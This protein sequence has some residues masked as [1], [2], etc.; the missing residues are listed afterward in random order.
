MPPL[1]GGRIHLDRPRID[2]LLDEALQS[3]LVTVVAGAG[4]GKS[5]AVYSWL[6]DKDVDAA[7]LQFSTRDNI[8]D[9]FWEHFARSVSAF[10]PQ[11]AERLLQQGFPGTERQFERYLSIPV[12]GNDPRRRYVFVYD[13]IHLIQNESVLWFLNRSLSIPFPNITSILI[14]RKE[15]PLNLMR[16]LSKGTLAQI[17]GDQLRFSFEEMEALFEI[18]GIHASSETLDAVY[19]DTEGWAFALHLAG[20]YL[21]KVPQREG[22]VIPAI[23][24]NIFKLIESEV[25]AESGMELRKFLIKASLLHM[26][27]KE[28]LAGLDQ[29]GG[30]LLRQLDEI[31]TFIQLDT[32]SN[33]YYIHHLF[34]DYLVT[35]QQ[36]LTPEE[37]KDVW[38]QAARWSLA[39]GQKNDA[40][41]YYDK[42]GDYAAVMKLCSSFPMSMPNQTAKFLYEAM[43]RMP[44]EVYATH[45]NAYVIL[46]RLMVMLG[47]VGEAETLLTDIIRKYEAAPEDEFRNYVLW[48]AY[49]TIGF[50]RKLLCLFNG[51]YDFAEY[52]IKGRHYSDL[53]GRVLEGA[54]RNAS[55][56]AYA[57][58]V[59]TPAP[60][61]LERFI[62]EETAMLP[63]VA[64]AMAGCMMGQDWVSRG[65]TAFFRLD[66]DEAERCLLQAVPQA[67][68]NNQYDVESQALFYRL[69]VAI[70][71][72]RTDALEGVVARY[73]ELLGVEEHQNRF[74]YN[75]IFLGWFHAH[76][77]AVEKV[78]FWLRS[79]AGN[80]GI[81]SHLVGL[82]ELVRAKALLRER[83]FAASLASLGNARQSAGAFIFGKVEIAVLEALC[84]YQS[85]ERAKAYAKLRQAWEFAAPG[86]L[87]L[88]FAEQ[89]KDMRTLATAAAKDDAP[90]PK[91]FL[92]KVRV[93][94]SAYAKKFFQVAERFAAPAPA[95]RTA[96]VRHG[97][98]SL[99]RKEVEMLEWLFRGFTLEEIAGEAKLSINTVKS[100]VKRVY[101]KLGTANRTET[102][103]V[104]ISQG[105]LRR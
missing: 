4:Y 35:L 3:P 100:T 5:R 101:G 69:R 38:M 96:G 71:Q 68:R 41:S 55:I 92:E 102:I 37:K 104:A 22:R 25:L 60:K 14:S 16:H 32:Y 83:K 70:Y 52:F 72:G 56:G 34:L 45:S 105:L 51:D 79:E 82:D 40:I 81:S 74:I 42:A 30:G 27:A 99:S 2:A 103:R 90:I 75:D 84:L 76:L 26:K 59:G 62:E 65:E 21:K 57:C 53:C 89:G 88:P 11:T 18:F 61:D 64:A 24:A 9:R 54:M 31:G 8:A 43:R 1:P 46:T 44:D 28:L 97:D 91:A 67:R 7:W 23:R 73:R 80:S 94:S 36:E 87:L 63:H 95:G 77:G 15:P 13:D 86:G 66:M 49:F 20:I 48:G 85:Q 17:T 19:R 47:K 78:A 33:I 10:S 6:Q 12:E 29:T 93:L 39:N 50:I 98:A 58:R